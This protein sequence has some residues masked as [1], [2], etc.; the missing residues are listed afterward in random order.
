MISFKTI[1]RNY[2]GCNPLPPALSVAR[3]ACQ[4]FQDGVLV[5]VPK[6][7]FFSFHSDAKFSWHTTSMIRI[8]AELRWLLIINCNVSSSYYYFFYKKVKLAT[9]LDNLPK[10]GLKLIYYYT[11]RCACLNP[12][13]PNSDLSQT[14]HCNIK[15]LSVSQVMRIENMITQV[16]FY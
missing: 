13:R 4:L 5:K 8:V 2:S 7:F 1:G 9:I 12:F 3:E 11:K 14:S 10:I 6:M 15:R 16:Q